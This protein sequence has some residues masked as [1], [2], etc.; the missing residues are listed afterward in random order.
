MLYFSQYLMDHPEQRFISGTVEM[1]LRDFQRRN[2]RKSWWR[3]NQTIF[4][5]GPPGANHA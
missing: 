1:M 5:D 2:Q 4:L 3:F